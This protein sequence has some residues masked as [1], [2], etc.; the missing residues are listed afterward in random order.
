MFVAIITPIAVATLAGAGLDDL[1]PPLPPPLDE[2]PPPEAPPEAAEGDAGL[3]L[4]LP[5]SAA[6]D[7]FKPAEAF[8]LDDA[9][10]DIIDWFMRREGVC[11]C[12]YSTC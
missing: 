12:T 8:S 11:V 2:S 1:P 4:P 7:R 3:P 5:P 9:A 6:P 10:V